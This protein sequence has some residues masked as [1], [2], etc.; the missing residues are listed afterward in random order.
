VVILSDG[1]RFNGKVINS[2]ADINLALIEIKTGEDLPVAFLGD[3]DRLN[4]GDFVVAIGNPFGLGHVATVGIVS[5]KERAIPGPYRDFIQTDAAIN[6][7]NS[8]GPLFNVRGEIVGINAAVIKNE[9]IGFVLP[10]NIVKKMLA[11]LRS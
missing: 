1:R 2:D 6:P 11:R 8:G 7:G 5:A 4:V 10:I 9:G 3:S